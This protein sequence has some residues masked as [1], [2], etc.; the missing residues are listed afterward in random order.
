MAITVT[1]KA[2]QHIKHSLQKRGQGVGLRLG[3]KAMGC[4]GYAYVV[5]YADTIRADDKVFESNGIKVIVNP[6]SLP[7]V[8]GTGI[9]YVRQGP[10]ESFQFSNPN[11]KA[12]CGCG[13]SFGV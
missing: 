12:L 7:H 10:N 3:V 1:A 8:D 5:D 6:E 9:D 11:V 2:A 4:S 13:E